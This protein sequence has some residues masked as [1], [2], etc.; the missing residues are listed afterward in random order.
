MMSTVLLRISFSLL[1]SVRDITTFANLM[2]PSQ[3]QSAR[4][5]HF[6]E[7]CGVGLLVLSKLPTEP[8]LRHK[9]RS[10]PSFFLGVSRSRSPGH[11]IE[12]ASLCTVA[13]FILLKMSFHSIPILDLS[14]AQTESTKP[15]FL[16]CLRNALLDIGFLYI[17]NTGIEDSLIQ[18]VIEQG[19][20][21]FDLPEEKKL[22]VQM[23]NKPSF[24]GKC[25]C[26]A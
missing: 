22:E 6:T 10:R 23:K 12:D 1:T 4:G 26:T 16:E 7:C 15:A 2:L 9:P 21:F 20:A 25:S 18:N 3:R 8:R 11:R 14:L 13:T 19:K 17:K 24:L 5:F